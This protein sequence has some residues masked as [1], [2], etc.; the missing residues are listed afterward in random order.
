MNAVGLMEPS[1]ADKKL[2]SRNP[3]NMS[4]E[5]KAKSLALLD[6]LIAAHEAKLAEL[7]KADPFWYFEPSDGRVSEEGM[8][9]LRKYLKEEDIPQ[10]FDS[11]MDVLKS[12]APICGVS[13]GNQCLGG[14]QEIY[15]P[16]EGI[17]RR[18]DS[19]KSGFFVKAWDGKRVVMA[20]A[21]APFRKEID[22]IYE[23]KFSNGEK[24][25]SSMSHLVLSPD[26][27][28]P[29]SSLLE[30]AAVFRPRSISDTSPSI[31]GEDDPSFWRKVRGSLS[32][33]LAY[34][35]SCGGQPRLVLS[36]APGVFPSQC[37]VHG[38]KGQ[39]F[40]RMDDRECKQGHIPSCQDDAPPSSPGV[41]RRT[42]ALASG[43]LSRIGRRL[44]KSSY[45]LF[46]I[47][48]QPPNVSGRLLQSICGFARQAIQFFLS[49][50]LPPDCV[51]V[52]KVTHLRKDY[53]WDFEVPVFHNYVAGG[54]VNHNS[55]K[56]TAVCIKRLIRSIGEV[57][58]A[59]KGI[60]PMHTIPKKEPRRYRVVAED[61]TNGILKNLIPLYQH[62]VPREYLIGQDWSKSWTAMSNTLT[63]VH[64]Q[65]KVVVAT[66]EFMSNAGDVMSHQG[67]PR[68][69]V[70]FDEE[71]RYEIYKEN[72]VRMATAERLDVQ[73][74]MTPTHGLSWTHDEI[75]T[76]AKDDHGNDI[77]WF[78]VS[79]VTNP[80]ANLAVVD[81][82][83]QGLSDYTDIKMRLL[84]E[85]VSLSGLIYGSLFDRKIHVIEPFNLDP[86]EYVVYR[87]LDPHT[88]KPT[89]CVEIAVDR[90]GNEY[91]CGLY[92]KAVDTDVVKADLAARVKEKRYRLGKTVCDR[93]ADSDNHALGDR[94]IY[95]ELRRG[96]NAI[97]ALFKSE[98]YKGSIDAGVDLIKQKLK[99]NPI[100]GKPSLFVFNTPEMQPLIHAF[101]TL[102]REMFRD[103]KNQGIKDK[104]KE[105]P[106]DAH[107]AFRYP[108]Q[109][110]M[111]WFPPTVFAETEAEPV[112]E[113]VGW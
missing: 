2:L 106:H 60:F 39:A 96:N 66:I 40:S 89:Y 34:F 112:S 70:D 35:R 12:D 42:S 92:A 82:I 111:S 15:D 51:V 94:N 31:L 67:P 55:G 53:K 78:K 22:D 75:Y 68:D 5:E 90:E 101:R 17:S 26:G 61:Y 47:S 52:T 7:K 91:A 77:D 102:E 85:F 95:D 80:K 93:S 49:P 14:E 9:L 20:C 74:G 54:V 107:A 50:F 87:G 8:A 16:V 58:N 71:P 18:V 72:I 73:F 4:P 13:G 57:P 24:L 30:G 37:D 113:A 79:S 41:P 10:R 6:E 108:H 81:E 25:T 28:V 105:G 48:V 43:F 45:R 44:L 109:I 46:P 103:E 1:R 84:G 3:V 98:K 38:H 32:D 100:T 65:R 69:G 36:T 110:R 23:F 64:P 11:Q 33:C 99:V 86:N 76:K 97:P 88:A 59:L 21:M 27:F 83:V 29:I 56:S 62:W 63:L 104:I 19:I